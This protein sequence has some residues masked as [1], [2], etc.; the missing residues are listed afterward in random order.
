MKCLVC[1]R[2]MTEKLITVD[3]RI[4]NKLLIVERVPATACENCG[5]KVFSPAVTRKLQNLAKRRRK[6]RR[7]LK[8]PVFSLDESLP[9][10]S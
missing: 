7:T 10:A 1:H 5:E 8:V 9:T 2:E 6:P 3:L 4:G